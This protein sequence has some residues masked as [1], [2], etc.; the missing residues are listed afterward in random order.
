MAR[1][2]IPVPNRPELERDDY[3]LGGPGWIDEFGRT[4][5][6][7]RGDAASMN[8]QGIGLRQQA[9]AVQ[10]R[11][12]PTTNFGRSQAFGGQQTGA[13]D[14]MRDFANGP[15]GPS[16]AQAQLREGANTSMRQ[17]L[18]AARSGSGFGESANALASAQRAN[19]DTTA[20]TANSAAQLR[21]A[22][23]QAFQNRR[24][25]AMT[26][27][28]DIYGGAAARE[29][30]QAQFGTNADIEA[31]RMR[32][33]MQL[34]LGQQSIDA[35]TAGVQGQL[36]AEGQML[37]SQRAALEGRVAQGQQAGQNYATEAD[38]FAT[39]EARD[40]AL[41]EQRRAN[42]GEAASIVGGVAGAAAAMFSDER[43]KKNVRRA[44]LESRYAA[45]RD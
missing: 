19:A 21:A 24:L 33:A 11:Q 23:D 45:L 8:V 34:G 43:T 44:N 30:E 1:T 18:A 7:T 17:T 32:D 5:E 12:G 40:R 35:Q 9:T 14:W 31:Q 22:E 15:Q 4:A 16:A 27:A 36:G 41:A 28:A 37:D 10:D 39:R 29:G 13:A 2:K 25:A 42:C 26:G 38:V 20:S 3:T 6:G